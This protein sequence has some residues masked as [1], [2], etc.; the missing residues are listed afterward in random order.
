MAS[1]DHKANTIPDQKT[2]YIIRHY[3]RHI[4][5][6]IISDN[7]VMEGRNQWKLSVHPSILQIGL[8][9]AIEAPNLWRV[10]HQDPKSRR[11][12]AVKYSA[13]DKKT[14][15]QLRDVGEGE[16]NEICARIWLYLSSLT[17]KRY[18]WL[19]PVLA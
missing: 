13:D 7:V 3:N 14:Y 19:S 2:A 12:F 8:E 6:V 18:V 11:E 5:D 17:A 1:L 4:I 10:S 15:L 16:Y 9:M